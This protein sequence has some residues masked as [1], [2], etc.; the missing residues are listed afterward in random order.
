MRVLYICYD[1][2]RGYNGATRHI[3]EIA[4]H[5]QELGHVV[6]LCA[7]LIGKHDPSPQVPIIYIPTLGISYLRMASYCLLSLLFLPIHVF[8][9]K[10]DVIYI[11]D[12]Y[13]TPL[14]VI[15][16]KILR[17]PCVLE[18]NDLV[19]SVS[20]ISKNNTLKRLLFIVLTWFRR[21]QFR[22]CDKIITV[23][24]EL[25]DLLDKRYH[26]GGKVSVIHNGVDTRLFCPMDKIEARKMLK[27]DPNRCYVGFVGAFYSWHGLE[28]LVESVPRII[29]QLPDVSFLLVGDGKTFPELIRLIKK[30]GLIDKFILPGRVPFAAVPAYINAFD[31]G[32]N[33]FKLTQDRAPHS[34]Y[35]VKLN[36]YLACEKP[37]IVSTE[38]EYLIRDINAGISVD[39]SDPNQVVNAIV[40]LREE[41]ALCAQMGK[42]GRREVLE[43]RSWAMK[44]KETETVLQTILAKGDLQ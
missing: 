35:P 4:K 13:F 41:P 18:V 24:F 44:A 43:N 11:R 34:G 10:P 1:D 40:K 19:E 26:V 3:T 29:N 37:V 33:F 42:N 8:N 36:E 6:R 30:K 9:L 21:I 27:L 7:P 39:A 17:I 2:M 16:S 31:L 5:L 20:S 28:Y 38:Y 25:K 32:I 23:T 12:I 15:L 14:P 22:L